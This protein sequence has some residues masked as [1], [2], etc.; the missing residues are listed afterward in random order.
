[1]NN[2]YHGF[3][4][5]PF[6]IIQILEG[7]P[8]DCP[9]ITDRSCEMVSQEKQIRSTEVVLVRNTVIRLVQEQ[10]VH[11]LLG[12]GLLRLDYLGEERIF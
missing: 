12:V 10:V 2:K 3:F 11:H 5:L 7:Q 8:H 9:S 6:G 4:L 1:M